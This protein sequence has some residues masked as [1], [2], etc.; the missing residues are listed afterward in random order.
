[1]VPPSS[2]TFQKPTGF[3]GKVCAPA[4]AVV[5][6]EGL[7]TA[8]T[9]LLHHNLVRSLAS[10]ERSASAPPPP[11]FTDPKTLVF[12]RMTVI[13]P[14]STAVPTERL[15]EAKSVNMLA[16]VRGLLPDV[17]RNTSS[18]SPSLESMSRWIHPV[19]AVSSRLN[20]PV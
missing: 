5:A 6:V 4:T 7:S 8:S 11:L 9:A 19:L 17:A 16:G 12:G 3:A 13:V 10:S 14:P 18:L 20:V 1:V 2:D 15:P